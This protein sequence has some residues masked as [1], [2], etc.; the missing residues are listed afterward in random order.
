ME[1]ALVNFKMH[2]KPSLSDN[3]V[4]LDNNGFKNKWNSIGKGEIFNFTF[5]VITLTKKSK[6]L[7]LC[8]TFH[9]YK[10][11]VVQMPSLS[12]KDE[13]GQRC[14]HVC[15]CLHVCFIHKC[16][17]RYFASILK[18]SLFSVINLRNYNKTG[19]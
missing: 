19:W 16:L 11:I 3:D 1:Q 7:P 14:L 4:N 18:K 2:I 12:D 15:L 17:L 8:I 13:L 5:N 9:L 6:N 10:T